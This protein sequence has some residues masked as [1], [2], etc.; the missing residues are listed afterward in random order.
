MPR[1]YDE[2]PSTT[3]MEGSRVCQKCGRASDTDLYFCPYCG[4]VF[5]EPMPA[6]FEPPVPRTA[7]VP[8]V[9][10]AYQEQYQRPPEP[11]WSRPPEVPYSRPS[12]SPYDSWTRDQ[13]RAFK[14][15]LGLG[16]LGFMGMGHLYM[17]KKVKGLILLLVGGFLATISLTAWLTVWDSG[18]SLA[19]TLIT[20]MVLSVPFLALQVW[21]A[22]DAPRP[23]KGF[24]AP[25]KNVPRQRY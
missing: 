13:S 8:P 14:I 15:G 12:T 4:K 23:P 17:G 5:D 18:Y 11:Q 2:K 24:Y 22:F 16:F 6:P 20:A 9:Q 3:P 10:P 7:F 25:Y 19:V 21:Q 1:G